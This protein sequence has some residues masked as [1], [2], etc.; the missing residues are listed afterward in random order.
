LF[1]PE[2]V[3]AQQQKFYGDIVLIHPFSLTF[4]TLLAVFL[5]SIVFGFLILEPYTDVAH[6]SGILPASR[7]SSDR[8]PLAKLYVPSRAIPFMRP[9]ENLLVRCSA[10]TP[11]R[12]SGRVREVSTSPLQPAELVSEA[13]IHS[14]QP[15]YRVTVALV[16]DNPLQSRTEIEADLPLDRK[17]LLKWLFERSPAS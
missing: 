13:G 12:Q 1:R 2:A 9:G 6:V 10:C 14:E 8:E 3:A 4:L 17:P 5:V 15:L 16:H 11:D 7:S